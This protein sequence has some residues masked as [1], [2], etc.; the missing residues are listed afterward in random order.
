MD[1]VLLKTT[2]AASED[3]QPKPKKHTTR[4]D[5]EKDDFDFIVTVPLAMAALPPDALAVA[6]FQP[7]ETPAPVRAVYNADRPETSPVVFMYMQRRWPVM[8]MKL[9][10]PDSSGAIVIEPIESVLVAAIQKAKAEHVSEIILLLH[11]NAQIRTAASVA[12]SLGFKIFEGS[13]GTMKVNSQLQASVSGTAAQAPT[14]CLHA[15][16]YQCTDIATNPLLYNHLQRILQNPLL[17]KDKWLD[18]WTNL[19]K[20][21]VELQGGKDAPPSKKKYPPGSQLPTRSLASDDDDDDNTVTQSLWLLTD[22]DFSLVDESVYMR[23][24]SG[25]DSAGRELHPNDVCAAALTTTNRHERQL[26]IDYLCSLRSSA[27]HVLFERMCAAAKANG[28]SSVTLFPVNS[29]VKRY[30]ISTF[31]MGNLFFGSS[32]LYKKL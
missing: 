22:L 9:Y 30:Y 25:S 32:Y 21:I 17:C 6:E 31:G 13:T 29:A 10:V 2:Y 18:I 24:E 16:E 23:P 5:T 27:G 1:R 4:R 11:P 26:T 12:S 15:Q 28:C 7:F 19:Q 20:S 3:D 8:T 14:R